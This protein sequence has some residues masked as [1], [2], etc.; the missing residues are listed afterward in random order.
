[1]PLPLSWIFA[2]ACR[3]DQLFGLCKRQ[4]TQMA[5]LQWCMHQFNGYTVY[6][7]HIA[8]RWNLYDLQPLPVTMI[9]IVWAK[10]MCGSVCVCAC[11]SICRLVSKYSLSVYALLC[12]CLS[13]CDARVWSQPA[14]RTI[15]MN[16]HIAHKSGHLWSYSIFLFGFVCANCMCSSM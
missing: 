12:H 5:L 7:I 8:M 13:V 14:I 15:A 10:S 2:T 9:L 6:L 11:A 4:H 3:I 1:M 16:P